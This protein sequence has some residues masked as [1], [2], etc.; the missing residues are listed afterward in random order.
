MMAKEKKLEIGAINITIQPHTPDMYLKLFREVYKLKTPIK[1][2]GDQFA[3]IASIHKLER[4]QVEPGPITGD[5]YRYTAIDPE[6]PWFDLKTGDFADGSL[7]D[8]INIPENLKPNGAR[9]SYIFY[10]KEHLLFYE[11]YY[12]SKTF[13]AMSAERFVRNLLNQPSILGKYGKID[14]THIPSK[15]KLND[16]LKMPTKEVIEL[17]I[18]R[19]NGDTLG[20]TQKRVM[21]RMNALNVETYE[22]SY[23]AV[24]GRSIDVDINLKTMA[25]IAASNGKVSIKGK[26][27]NSKPITFSTTEHPLKK[28]QYFDPNVQDAFSV[29]IE[30][31]SK[32]KDE[33]V[34]WFRS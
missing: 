6:A 13:G 1:V 25:K 33:I 21:D 10:P 15:D 8:E 27:S 30:L 19:P 20:K 17:I 22:E 14:V 2:S 26:D 29:L 4:G 9:F 7:L 5:F 11:S 34:K 32:L 12:D 23:K 24:Q 28:K 31:S 16:A 3:I 18:T